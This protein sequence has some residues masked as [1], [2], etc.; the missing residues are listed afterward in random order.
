MTGWLGFATG[1]EQWKSEEEKT[2]LKKRQKM[3]RKFGWA[4]G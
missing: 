3:S 2:A 4:G 1:V